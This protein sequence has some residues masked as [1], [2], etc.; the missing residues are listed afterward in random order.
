[1]YSFELW[2]SFRILYE[3]FPELLDSLKH[4]EHSEHSKHFKHF[5]HVESVRLSPEHVL[6]KLILTRRNAWGGLTLRRNRTAR[7]SQVVIRVKHSEY[8]EWIEWVE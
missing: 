3:C 4:S 5:E 7:I 1:M 8:L 6:K 2:E